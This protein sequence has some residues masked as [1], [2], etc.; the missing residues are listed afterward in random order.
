MFENLNV[1]RRQFDQKD[2]SKA[3]GKAYNMITKQRGL[4]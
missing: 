2:I 4:R 1:D 3:Y